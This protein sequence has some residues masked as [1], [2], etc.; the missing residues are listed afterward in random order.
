MFRAFITVA[1]LL[2][3]LSA[4]AL[5]DTP[6]LPQRKTANLPY[7][8]QELEQKQQNKAQLEKSLKSAEEDMAAT[9]KKLVKA[10]ESVQAHEKLLRALEDRIAQNAQESASLEAGLRQDYGAISELILTLTRMRRIPPETL[11]VRPGAPLETAQSAL[12]LQSM[13]KTVNSRALQLSES[14][15]KLHTT[16]QKLAADRAQ[17][18]ETK[19]TLDGRYAKIAALAEKRERLY[20][21][22]NK[23]YRNAA[24]AVKRLAKEARNLQDLMKRLEEKKQPKQNGQFKT[25]SRA[26]VPISRGQPR[27]PAFGSILTRFHEKDKIGAESQGITIESQPRAI[28]VCPIGGV[29]KFA[30]DFKDYGPVVIVE[31][32]KKHH[33]LIIGL[34]KITVVAGQQLDA[35]EPVGR[36]PATSSRGTLPTLYYELRQ[37]GRPI[38]PAKKFADLK[39]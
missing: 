9:K 14:L 27:L 6:P 23:N 39:S 13:L 16:Q 11:I 21:K 1:C 34:D 4:P 32:E 26:A 15:Q 22:T 25:A 7:L 33:S 28:V 10:A 8:Q 29:V 30:G 24:T 19:A 38:D 5:A 35:G 20:K 3:Y 37:R 18:L 17:A 12:L 36:L 31:H 2:L